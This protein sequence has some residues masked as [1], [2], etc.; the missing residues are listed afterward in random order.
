MTAELQPGGKNG[1]KQ[2]GNY[3][4]VYI[5]KENLAELTARNSREHS[6]ID[7]EEKKYGAEVRSNFMLLQHILARA[8]LKYKTSE[9]IKNN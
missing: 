6:L 7:S 2:G 5:R 3:H 8:N 4:P 9:N 1:Q